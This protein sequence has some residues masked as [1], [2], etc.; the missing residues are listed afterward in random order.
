MILNSVLLMKCS[1]WRGMVFLVLMISLA[2]CQSLTGSNTWPD[3]VPERGFFLNAYEVD[4]ENQQE[5]T[6]Q[7]YLNWI[8]RFYQ[9][10]DLMSTG[11]NELTPAVLMGMS[12]ETLT[13][14]EKESSELGLAISSEWAKDNSVR[15][16]N[17]AMLSL[18]GTVMLS[19]E[20]PE[21]RLR[22]LRQ[23]ASD[24]DAIMRGELTAE[25][26]SDERYMT[27]LDLPEFF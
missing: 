23:I 3:D 11:W 26:I 20:Q 22:A 19:V 16:I 14:A 15:E 6:Q 10:S 18:W 24:V 13:A 25:E 8:I 9:G 27:L 2:G 21:E 7:Q 1:A 12:G 4:A 5:Q 17:T